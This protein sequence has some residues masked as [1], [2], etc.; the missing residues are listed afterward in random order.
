MGAEM[1]GRVAGS[2]IR[3]ERPSG[4]CPA[5]LTRRGAEALKCRAAQTEHGPRADLFFRG[6]MTRRL[7]PDTQLVE[8]MA[9][10]DREAHGELCERHRLSIS[11]HVIL[12]TDDASIVGCGD[13][14]RT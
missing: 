14:S 1:Y 10:G 8:R 4:A 6:P 7:T 2:T 9:A 13:M 3:D 12:L 11:A 5:S